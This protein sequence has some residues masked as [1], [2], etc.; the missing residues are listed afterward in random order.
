MCAFVFV[1]VYVGYVFAGGAQRPEEGFR[2]PGAGVGSVNC[3]GQVLGTEHRP[4]RM[5]G[6]SLNCEAFLPNP[7]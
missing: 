4:C 7:N 5:T 6:S 3:S 2:V 1:H